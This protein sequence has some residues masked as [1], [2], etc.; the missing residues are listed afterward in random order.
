MMTTI[1]NREPSSE[2]SISASRSSSVSIQNQRQNTESLTSFG[3]LNEADEEQESVF[4]LGS[5]FSRVRSA[6]V[7]NEAS[8]P[9]NSKPITGGNA[10]SALEQ[11]LNRSSNRTVSA[12]SS[13]T[14]LN[15]HVNANQPRKSSGK[16]PFEGVS[17]GETSGSINAQIGSSK[18]TESTAQL[19]RPSRTNS[20]LTSSSKS[21]K[22]PFTL[23]S[24]SFAPAVTSTAAAHAIAPQRFQSFTPENINEEGGEDG[25]DVLSALMRK[26]GVDQS[27]WGANRFSSVPGFPL[28]KDTLADDTRSI[29]SSSSRMPRSETYSTSEA[30]FVIAHAQSPK[31][32]GNVG[33][34]EGQNGDTS[35]SAGLSASADAFRRMRGEGTVLSRDLWMPDENV[36][37]CRECQSYFTP[38]RRKHHCRICGL[39]YC[40]RCASNIVSGRRFGLDH[41]EIRVCNYCLRVL[42][43]YERAGRQSARDG[44]NTIT[45]G[46]ANGSPMSSPHRVAT[47]FARKRVESN[48]L[49]PRPDKNMISSPLEA[50]L[51]TPQSQFA[52]NQL[53]SH[54]R[55][56]VNSQLAIA[57]GLPRMDSLQDML[58]ELEED[59]RSRSQTP[60]AELMNGSDSP[61]LEDSPN[62]H[63]PFRVK[64]GEDDRI[65]ATEDEMP[66]LAIPEVDT[67]AKATEMAHAKKQKP[68]GSDQG[69]IKTIRLRDN[70][71]K[72]LGDSTI[73]DARER[74]V[75]EAALR[76]IRKSKLKGREHTQ[77]D[78]S[79][80]PGPRTALLPKGSISRRT[81]L[82][83]T[84]TV[85][86][87]EMDSVSITH[88]FA[89]LRQTLTRNKIQPIDAWQETLEPLLIN[90]VRHVHPR[91]RVGESMDVRQY[92]KFKRIAGGQISDSCYVNGFVLSKQVATKKMSR[93]L[94]L[95]N[96]RVMIVAFPIDFHRADE[97]FMSL[98]PVL[99]QEHEYTRILVA[100]LL[101]LR[102]NVLVV[103]DSVSRL[104][105][106]MLEEAGVVV[107]WSVKMSAVQAISRC[108]QADIISSVERLALEPRL[109][110]CASF[111]V[112]TYQHASSSQCRKSLMRFN[113]AGNA[114]TF[115]CSIIL[116]GA[117]L[118]TLGTIK[119]IASIMVYAAHNLRLEEQLN[120][121]EGAQLQVDTVSMPAN[122]R[123]GSTF[124]CPGQCDQENDVL[125]D[126]ILSALKPFETSILSASASINI[127]PPY[128]LIKMKEAHR[129][130]K[131]LQQDCSGETDVEKAGLQNHA[132]TENTDIDNEGKN[133]DEKA[134][135]LPALEEVMPKPSV[136]QAEYARALMDHQIFLKE[137]S[138]CEK[139]DTSASLR[140]ISVL[141]TMVSTA[142]HKPCMGP[143][144]LSYIFY[145]PQDETLGQ[146]LERA[147]LE[148]SSICSA[149]GCGRPKGVHYSSY[150]HN[151]TRVQVVLERFVCP[152]P[153]QE[154]RLLMWSYCK[155]CEKATPVTPVSDDTWSLSFAKYLELHFYDGRKTTTLC[156]HDYYADFVR[157]FSLQNLA[158]RFHRDRDLVVRD[159]VLPPMR[160]LPRPDIDYRLKVEGARL[161]QERMDAYWTS[162]MERMVAIRKEPSL[163][164]QH[165]SQLEGA[166][167]SAKND[168]IQL[169]SLLIETCRSSDQTDILALNAVRNRMQSFVVR[170]DQF[171]HEFER[172]ALPSDRDVRRMTTHHL[173]RIFQEKNEQPGANTDRVVEALGLSP[174]VEVDE[175]TAT[176]GIDAVLSASTTSDEA[177]TSIAK[178]GSIQSNLTDDTPLAE[179]S[180]PLL[181][182][183]SPTLASPTAWRRMR[184][185][186]QTT[187]ESVPSGGTSV[188]SFA[189]VHSGLSDSDAMSARPVMRRGK[190]TDEVHKVKT[191]DDSKA[192]S[193]TV[194]GKSMIPRT[195]QLP[196]VGPASPAARRNSGFPKRGPPSSY[197][198]PKSIINS[199]G[200]SSAFSSGLETESDGGAA[201][202][203]V[204]GGSTLRRKLS[205][206][207]RKGRLQALDAAKEANQ[208]TGNGK[209][210]IRPSSR[211]PI[212][213]ANRSS[214]VSTI[215]RRFD[216]LQKEAERERERQRLVR[217]RRARPVGASQATVQVYRSLKDAV[218]DEDDDESDSSEHGSQR[219]HEA[220]LEDE[221]DS[222]A[223]RGR[224]R[225]ANGTIKAKASNKV[226]QPGSSR[227]ELQEG[228][229]STI[230]AGDTIKAAAIKNA[231]ASQ[232][233]DKE[234]NVMSDGESVSTQQNSLT[235]PTLPSEY[236][237]SPDRERRSLRSESSDASRL[238]P[239]VAAGGQGP[240]SAGLELTMSSLLSGTIPASWRASLLPAETDSGEGRGSLLKTISSLWARGTLNLPNIELPMRSTEHLF[241]DSPLVV[242]REDEPSSLIAFTLSSS[243]YAS[244]LDSLRKSHAPMQEDGG[245]GDHSMDSWH[246]IEPKKLSS[247]PTLQTHERQI[248]SALRQAEGTHLSFQF[249]SGDSRFSIRVLFTEQ[250]DALRMA[251]DCNQTFVQSLARCWNWSDCS[252]GKSGAAMM[253]TLDDRFIIKQL[254]RAEMD[255]FASNAGAYFRFLADVIFQDR[256]TTL[257]KIYGVYRLTIK[258]AQTGKSI[259]LDCAIT[260]NVFANAKMQQIFDLKGALRNRFVQPNG[261]PNQVLL[262]G[263]LITSK[264]PIY[265]R[266]G[267]K[268]LLR[269]ALLHDS[270]FL[271][272]CD[273]MD[274]SLVVGVC[275]GRPELRVGIIDF[276]RTFTFGKKAESFLK[277]AVGG[278]GSEAPTIID[279]KQYRARFLAFL[280]S[281]LLLSPDHWLS[282]DEENQRSAEMQNAALAAGLSTNYQSAN[283]AS[284]FTQPNANQSISGLTA[285]LANTA[286]GM[287]MI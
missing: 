97:Q 179:T 149:K 214:K 233:I 36:K 8:L 102:P 6:L 261:Q 120:R 7:P 282:E 87:D 14:A 132:A 141:W 197:R 103:K 275:E 212:S 41:A 186:T 117:K 207:K 257:A 171:F 25:E 89:L 129:R 278:H 276:I 227:N 166:M 228:S 241:S 71:S 160:H 265:L 18:I 124:L 50:Q 170:W 17:K 62:G 201:S 279:P 203:G 80:L 12:S 231:V 222:D 270:L 105:M 61:K 162:V 73:L 127:S 123:A 199:A 70:R 195:T 211:V 250:F 98:Q 21:S 277:E 190:T 229:G 52:A 57:Q 128:Q 182:P 194:S 239:V 32:G 256:P 260:E 221:G 118:E 247:P 131:C 112:D 69:P 208:K 144:L 90:V 27:R 287:V 48:G 93:M 99:A 122:R 101:Q 244:R 66:Q 145:G 137:W 116:R 225:K 88:L 59:H 47:S 248:E 107:V 204:V 135:I 37:E 271:A 119:M 54:Q 168:E 26:S 219:G 86:S 266:E 192:I 232:E 140:K 83:S 20:I 164:V 3:F 49:G 216:N 85:R 23:T 172:A 139:E 154:N 13:T 253:K 146:Y 104:A 24:T 200:G 242:L 169:K 31:R 39:V 82:T 284:T 100:R 165:I 217:A 267:S 180:N 246:V 94:P 125:W 218:R 72:L 258:N 193:G 35:A 46:S 22:L 238:N 235:A 79:S 188:Q 234:Q 133:S 67:Q 34:G 205:T 191:G 153:G 58:L 281:V 42:S 274:Y 159:V 167:Q 249:T 51:Q 28:S 255:A 209:D 81:S 223:E 198:P 4:A 45:T 251:C 76:H 262:D 202:S 15:A 163:S 53:F 286:P 130:L 126:R 272:Q 40:S 78:D 56:A 157:F 213:T 16:L 224:R 196:S 175:A 9:E 84:L 150:V 245:L 142:T 134:V 63:V 43:E 92:I 110:R 95:S 10:S 115:G 64:L 74:G 189:D 269:Q 268:R 30:Q 19:K 240:E 148:S 185:S 259:K 237:S 220:E 136:L 236:E 1:Q 108:C 111:A 60:I 252:G 106:D 215:A 38:F 11:Q 264:V 226:A 109:G 138:A 183:S 143:T 230:K 114:R 155:K 77:A 177:K 151:D 29:H 263:N 2:R 55:G 173:S 184:S 44:G 243:T 254:S 113:T 283:N 178:A 174:A 68:L 181:T 96:P 91:P 152:I 33:R 206:S 176:A 5:L 161:L 210:T 121:D 65:P 147:C 75:G 280:D 156:G 285:V 187:Q 273:V 158:I